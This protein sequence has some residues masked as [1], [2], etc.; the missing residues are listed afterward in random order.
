MS[1]DMAEN[2]EFSGGVAWLFDEPIIT[3]REKWDFYNWTLQGVDFESVRR[4]W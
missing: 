3:G 1:E 4:R 2:D